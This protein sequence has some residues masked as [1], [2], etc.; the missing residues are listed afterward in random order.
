MVNPKKLEYHPKKKKKKKN[1]DW[2][3]K[4]VFMSK[5][6]KLC[7]AEYLKVYVTLGIAGK[8]HHYYI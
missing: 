1:S 4:N 6:L 7:H 2:L 3:D 5:I 8:S